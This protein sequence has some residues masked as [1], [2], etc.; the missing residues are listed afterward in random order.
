MA[1][2]T[3]AADRARAVIDHR[4]MIRFD[5]DTLKQRPLARGPYGTGT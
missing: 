5:E 1:D 3:E 2:A 4:F